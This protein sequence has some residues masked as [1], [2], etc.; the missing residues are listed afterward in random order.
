MSNPPEPHV[1]AHDRVVVQGASGSGK[2][3]FARELARILDVP[4]LELDSLYH[5]EGWTALDVET[6]REHVGAFAQQP[7]WV[8]DGNYSSVRDLLWSRAGV[9]L[10]IDL[11]RRQT[12]ARLL[13][14]TIRRSLS[15]EE[16]WN[17]NRES[18][19]HLF[20]LDPEL[21]VVL[22]SWKTHG[23]YHESVPN[24][25]RVQAPHADVKIL[26]NARE[27]ASHLECLRVT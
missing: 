12:V 10:F 3:T 24:E 23:R 27:V 20:S 7:R 21:N 18:L 6:F 26:R 13:R 17:G 16:L 2:S 22:W 25:A 9:I 15:G 1:G 19:R 4:Y 5:Q 8:S 11:P 14:R